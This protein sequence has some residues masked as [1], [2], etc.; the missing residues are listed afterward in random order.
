[1]TTPPPSDNPST[2]V[3]PD[4]CPDEATLAGL[5]D[6][7]D[8]DATQLAR[9]LDG[10]EACR[11]RLD[12]MAGQS[13]SPGLARGPRDDEIPYNPDAEPELH[14]ALAAARNADPHRTTPTRAP[15]PEE[16]QFLSPLRSPGYIGSLGPYDII[17][18]VGQGGMGIVLK[19]HDH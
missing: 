7:P 14:R 3:L 1:M 2:E 17:Q 8:A 12:A 4:P 13:Y 19:A 11:T 10:C 5:L 15:L 6:N 18:C 9:H 16:L